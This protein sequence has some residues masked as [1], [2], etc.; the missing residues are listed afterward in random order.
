MP[1]N[2]ALILL[3]DCG[4]DID[5]FPLSGWFDFVNRVTLLGTN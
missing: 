4:E 1:D 3:I 2:E 5:T